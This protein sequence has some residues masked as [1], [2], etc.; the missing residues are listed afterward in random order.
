MAVGHYFEGTNGRDKGFSES[1]N[2]STWSATT[3]PV[4]SE[5]V[6]GND[7]YGISCLSAN[8]CF[9]VGRRISQEREE[10]GF[11]IP[12]EE[13]TLAEAWN[14]S[15]WSLQGTANPQSTAFSAL[16]GI[17]CASSITC[18]AVG[19]SYPTSLSGESLTLGERYE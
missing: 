10:G 4:P 1:W 13:R 11:H 3:T 9:A 14:G 6:G 18:T 2:G 15:A 8:S 16:A 7:L 19:T 5:S 17:S 12:T